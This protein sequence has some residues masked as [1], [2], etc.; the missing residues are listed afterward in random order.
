MDDAVDALETAV[1]LDPRHAE[2]HALLGT[3]Y[4]M[5]IH[6]SMLRALRYGPSVQEHQKLALELGPRNPR[7]RYLL[8]TGRFHLAKDPAARREALHT[9]LE[10]EKLFAAEA[11]TPAKPFDPRWGRS[12]CL[13]FIGRA[14]ESLG[15]NEQAADYFRK[16][17]AIHPADHHARDGLARVTSRR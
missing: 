15:H 8:G 2:S 10:A 3:L 6:G 16:A 12:S 7:V 14:S 9:L 11:A 13:T 5:K 1:R 17:L 4:G